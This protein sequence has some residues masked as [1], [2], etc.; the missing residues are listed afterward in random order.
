LDAA[1]E[2]AHEVRIGRLGIARFFFA[3]AN[4][5]SKFDNGADMV[6]SP[7]SPL[8]CIMNLRT[9]DDRMGEACHH[10]TQAAQYFCEEDQ[11]PPAPLNVNSLS[12]L[13]SGSSV[14]GPQNDK[15]KQLSKRDS[16]ATLPQI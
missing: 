11:F 14:V 16:G 4:I 2:F 9:W 3:N 6:G 12:H 10:K 7:C 1:D 15:D 13:F 8:W 5:V